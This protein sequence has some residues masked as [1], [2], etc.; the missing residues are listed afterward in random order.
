MGRLVQQPA[1]R[2]RRQIPGRS[3]SQ[4]IPHYTRHLKP[5]SWQVPTRAIQTAGRCVDPPPDE[6]RSR[7]GDRSSRADHG[8]PGAGLVDLGDRHGDREVVGGSVLIDLL[9]HSAE[10]DRLGVDAGID[11][12]RQFEDCTGS[13]MIGAS[14]GCHVLLTPMSRV[15]WRRIKMGCY[16]PDTSGFRHHRGGCVL[17]RSERVLDHRSG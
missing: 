7:I 1:H 17:C 13:T 4:P 10:W 12:G 14:A 5:R 8:I 11:H 6:C 2:H 15:A 9:A 16:R 3:R